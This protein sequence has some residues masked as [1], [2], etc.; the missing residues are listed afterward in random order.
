MFSFSTNLSHG[1][2]PSAY[3]IYGDKIFDKCLIYAQ[4]PLS[5]KQNICCGLKKR[6]N[7]MKQFYVSTQ[8]AC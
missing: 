8:K 6:T 3:T 5:L 7:S 2:S 4:E 1:Q